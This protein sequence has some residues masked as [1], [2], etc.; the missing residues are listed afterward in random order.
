MYQ[1][2]LEGQF[3]FTTRRKRS[4]APASVRNPGVRRRLPLLST[5]ASA[6]TAGVGVVTRPYYRDRYDV[7]KLRSARVE[8]TCI[9]WT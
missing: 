9:P 2:T 5:T 7:T 4:P 1:A 6:T 8:V 3:R